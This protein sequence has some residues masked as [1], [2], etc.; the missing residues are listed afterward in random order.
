MAA[1][2]AGSA[3][4]ASSFRICSRHRRDEHLPPVGVAGVAEPFG[5]PALEALDLVGI[6]RDYKRRKPGFEPAAQGGVILHA[7]FEC[8]D[9][10]AIEMAQYFHSKVWS[11]GGL[12][13]CRVLCARTV[14]WPAP[15]RRAL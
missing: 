11:G 6:E 5:E 8:G 1:I 2:V 13:G 14:A 7:L 15:G 3:R 12:R 10:L 4:A 9:G